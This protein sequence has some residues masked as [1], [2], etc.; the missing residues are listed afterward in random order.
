MDA[1]LPKM[2]FKGNKGAIIASKRKQSAKPKQSITV[3]RVV[4]RDYPEDI[5]RTQSRQWWLRINIP[6]QEIYLRLLEYVQESLEN[7]KVSR[8]IVSGREIGTRPDIGSFEKS[9]VHIWVSFESNASMQ[10]V[11]DFFGINAFM[12]WDRD[13]WMKKRTGK[14]DIKLWNYIIKEETKIDLNEI[15]SYKY[16]EPN[17]P[18]KEWQE[19]YLPEVTQTIEVKTEVKQD[20]MDTKKKNQDEIASIVIKLAMEQKFEEIK[21]TYPAYYMNKKGVIESFRAQIPG[22]KPPSIHVWFYG[23]PEC[24][25]SLFVETFF[26]RLYKKNPNTMYWQQ[27]QQDY[28][29][30]ILLSDLDTECILNGSMTWNTLK[31]AADEGGFCIEQKYGGGATAQGQLIITSNHSISQLMTSTKPFEQA[32]LEAAIK[33]RYFEIDFEKL[34]EKLN[35]ELVSPEE[36]MKS[37]REAKRLYDQGLRTPQSIHESNLKLWIIHDQTKLDHFLDYLQ[38]LVPEPYLP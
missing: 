19:R 22:L 6:N 10:Q 1:Q 24:G 30:S 21:T 32:T 9:H 14:M 37:K 7:R 12:V 27:F 15:V 36:R 26:P 38:C 17:K 23:S 31:T 34:K 5:D 8:I 25:K 4:G 13:F 2:A 20:Q 11:E 16:P 33:R 3:R 29:R 28:H 35:L 18:I